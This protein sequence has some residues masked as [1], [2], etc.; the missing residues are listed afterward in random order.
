MSPSPL[1]LLT[2][3]DPSGAVAWADQ[4][5]QVA[6]EGAVDKAGLPYIEHPRRVAE[7]VRERGGDWVQIA[8]A[9]LHDVIEDTDYTL[10]DIMRAFCE[11]SGVPAHARSRMINALDALTHRKNEPRVV[12]IG[13][14]REFEDSRVV[15]DA[16]LS[17]NGDPVRLAMLPREE[18]ERLEAKYERDRATLAGV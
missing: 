18:R 5:A 10:D 14:V 6:H 12:Y 8:L 16:D 13:R 9:L 7:T 17:D 15:K 1:P 11:Q 2:S 3:S 4:V